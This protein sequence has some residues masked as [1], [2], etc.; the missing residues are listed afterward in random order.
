MAPKNPR[1]EPLLPTLPV[2]IAAAS[3]AEPASFAKA[4][5]S[6]LALP[7]SPVEPSAESSAHDLLLSP[8][9]AIERSFDAGPLDDT[10]S[11]LPSS[12]AGPS[13]LP[14]ASTGTILQN[15]RAIQ[16]ELSEQLAQM[17]SQLKR[18]ALHFSTSLE[19]DKAVVLEAQEKLERNYDVMTKEH[20]RLKDHHSKSWGTTWLTILSI[21]VAI[22]G[23]MLTF[24]VIR[25]T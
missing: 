19:T 5:S 11:L 3:Q 14:H 4:D 22:I 9:D 16:E 8:S 2:P 23:F 13:S 24:F 15:S 18:N 20:K 17:A 21:V 25:F 7:R 6:D 12:S 10:S 1:P